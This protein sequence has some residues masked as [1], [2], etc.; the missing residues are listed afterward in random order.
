MYK[1][2]YIYV[3]GEYRGS[4][5]DWR[6]GGSVEGSHLVGAKK[7]SSMLRLSHHKLAAA[8]DTHQTCMQVISC[9]ARVR[10]SVCVFLSVCVCV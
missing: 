2:I 6:K 5:G 3:C 8:L 10:I 9:G 1:Y 4:G 7:K